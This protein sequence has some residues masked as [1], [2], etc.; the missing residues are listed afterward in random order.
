M[1]RKL[2]RKIGDEEL[3]SRWKSGTSTERELKTHT[4]KR[5]NLEEEAEEKAW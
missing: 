1:A 2:K 3:K 5:L 4:R